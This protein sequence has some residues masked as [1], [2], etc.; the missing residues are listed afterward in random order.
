MTLGYTPVDPPSLV[1]D[2]AK[3]AL[4][5]MRTFHA[6]RVAQIVADN[7]KAE[8][9]RC[10]LRVA[11]AASSDLISTI[12]NVVVPSTPEP[13]TPTDDELYA[14]L[15]T[16]CDAPHLYTPARSNNPVGATVEEAVDVATFGVEY[17]PFIIPEF[18]KR[19]ANKDLR[20]DPAGRYWEASVAPK[21]R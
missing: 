12:E 14:A 8:R 4:E 21:L 9:V 3:P 15:L 5:F 19:V 20:S 2:T 11:A 6:G 7:A 10:A 1:P 17:A 13:R 18:K 16:A